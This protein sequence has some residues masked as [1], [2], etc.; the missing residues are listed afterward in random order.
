LKKASTLA[1]SGFPYINAIPDGDDFTSEYTEIPREKGPYGTGGASEA[2]QS[3]GHSAVL[4]AIYNAVG[5][6]ITSL[7]A[8]PEKVKRAIED[9]KAGTLKPQEKYYLG[10]DMHEILDYMKANPVL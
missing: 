8:T 6:R 3:A 7:P 5:V 9:K 2:Y 10:G 4:N 1:G